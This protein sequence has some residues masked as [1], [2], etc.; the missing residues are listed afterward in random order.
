MGGIKH[1]VY[2]FKYLLSWQTVVSKVWDE[3]RRVLG[4]SECCHRI[5]WEN[6]P[7]NMY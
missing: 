1:S 5:N 6:I 2:Q 7:I 4:E 3:E